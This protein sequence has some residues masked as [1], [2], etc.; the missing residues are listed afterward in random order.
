MC[1]EKGKRKEERRKNRFR[2]GGKTEADTK[3]REILQKRSCNKREGES[4]RETERE[5]STRQARIKKERRRAERAINIAR[6][7]SF[8]CVESAKC[9]FLSAHFSLRSFRVFIFDLCSL[10]CYYYYYY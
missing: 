4:K 5:M 3:F 9:S 8:Y 6:Y 7:G 2:A 1:E 10:F